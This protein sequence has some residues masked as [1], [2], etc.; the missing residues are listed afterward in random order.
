MKRFA[1]TCE[2]RE[3]IRLCSENGASEVILAA[4]GGSMTALETVSSGSI[5]EYVI[6]S[7][8][9]GLQVSV[10]MNRLFAQHE[11]PEGEKLVEALADSGADYIHY[12]DPAVLKWAREKGCA[13]KLVYRPDTLITSRHDAAVWMDTGIGGVCVSPLLT[14]EEVELI[15]ASVK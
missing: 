4:E 3:D 7:H 8:E 14:K 13:E 5:G 11:L 12:A 10:L 15:A 1:V 6:Y 9:T 2:S